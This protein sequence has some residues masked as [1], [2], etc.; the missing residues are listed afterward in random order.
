MSRP[1]NS[2]S[3]L[4]STFYTLL[5]PTNRPQSTILPGLRTPPP[6]PSP[7]TSSPI[8]MA[9]SPGHASL[10]SAASTSNPS[11]PGHRKP[12][13]L[14]ARNRSSMISLP[15]IQAGKIEEY[16]DDFDMVLGVKEDTK[17]IDE[18][19]KNDDEDDGDVN[20][21]PLPPPRHSRVDITT[22]PPPRLPPRDKRASSVH[23]TTSN[24][25]CNA[26]SAINNLNTPQKKKRKTTALSNVSTILLSFISLQIETQRQ[27]DTFSAKLKELCF[28]SKM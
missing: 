13:P 16:D 24:A 23:E 22:P 5:Q 15:I 20:P 6:I 1:N 2:I 7:S 28:W 14:P 8:H 11:T 21:P 10:S 25:R 26:N 3:V 17:N 27:N 12:P 18:D 19:I 4:R 9:S